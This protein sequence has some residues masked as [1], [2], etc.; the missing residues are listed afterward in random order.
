MIGWLLGRFLMKTVLNN[1]KNASSKKCPSHCLD[2]AKTPGSSAKMYAMYYITSKSPINCF[3]KTPIDKYSFFSTIVIVEFCSLSNTIAMQKP[4]FFIQLV[5]KAPFCITLRIITWVVAY[6]DLKK[7]T[8][9]IE[10]TKKHLLSCWLT[11]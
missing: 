11:F 1:F 6:F 5:F 9:Q 4:Q 8:F 3:R 7:N 10:K 2:W